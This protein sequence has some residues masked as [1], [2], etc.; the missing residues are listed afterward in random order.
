MP[1]NL[2]LLG[3]ERAADVQQAHPEITRWAIGGHSLGG[4]AAAEY[5]ARYPGTIQGLVFWASYPA[6]DVSGQAVP[7]ASVYGALD[8]GRANFISAEARARLPVGANFVEI[9]G[10]NHEQFGYY[11]GQPGDPPAQ[12][13]RA[14]QQAQAVAA[15]VQLLQATRLP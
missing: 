11:T 14:E 9:A 7:A 2:A 4:V 6:S 12:I 10:G 1:L 8:T 5:A 3:V 15:T 13:P